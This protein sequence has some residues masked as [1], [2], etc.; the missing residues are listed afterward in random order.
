MVVAYISFAVFRIPVSNFEV[1]IADA[2]FLMS[3]C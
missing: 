3:N 1:L 2:Q